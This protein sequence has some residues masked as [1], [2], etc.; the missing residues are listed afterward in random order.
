MDWPKFQPFAMLGGILWATGN[1]CSVPVIKTIG[2]AQGLLIWGA[3][4][5]LTG[6]FS[7]EF[8]IL[9]V[10]SQR[11][12][13]NHQW[14]NI[15]GVVIALLSLIT[16]FF[17]DTNVSKA[18]N[19]DDNLN[20]DNKKKTHGR[21]LSSNADDS[22]L[23]NVD[24]DNGDTAYKRMEDHVKDKD[25]LAISNLSPRFTGNSVYETPN[26]NEYNKLELA[27]KAKKKDN[28]IDRMPVTQRKTFGIL[29]AVLSGI[30]YGTNFN[31]PQYLIDHAKINI[32]DQKIAADCKGENYIFSHFCG[33]YLASTIYFLIYC[34]IMKNRP[35]VYPRAI[36]PG[37]ITGIMW[38][39]AQTSWFTANDNLGMITAF[40]IVTTLP[41]LIA[42]IW[43][44]CLFKEITGKKNLRILSVA[45]I[46]T[47]FS[48]V[49]ITLSKLDI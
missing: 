27:E 36:L 8:G 6:W 19:L 14:L 28:F 38:A 39:I 33:I 22:L 35:N 12:L 30:F 13:I 44:V 49:C 41:G 4:C 2:L 42:S 32:N 18:N 3:S 9:G 1:I 11:K 47:V 24:E 40:P 25:Y 17:V 26:P 20:N 7:A 5:M 23:D 15:L 45:F 16:Y 31:P 48:V 10:E 37:S 34:A 29:G 21:I 43:G 46:L